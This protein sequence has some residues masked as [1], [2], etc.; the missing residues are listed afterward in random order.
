MIITA[1]ICFLSYNCDEPSPAG[2]SH[3]PRSG[4]A[5]RVTLQYL[6]LRLVHSACCVFGQPHRDSAAQNMY[7]VTTG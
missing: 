6:H 3:V 7:T 2:C 5:I 1:V 4:L